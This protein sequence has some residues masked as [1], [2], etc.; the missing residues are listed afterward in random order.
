MVAAQSLEKRRQ[1]SA[2]FFQVII[3]SYIPALPNAGCLRGIVKLMRLAAFQHFENDACC[4]A[5][6]NRMTGLEHL[7]GNGV[8]SS[9]SVL[10]IPNDET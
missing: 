10:R 7:P 5:I 4:F 2:V 9:E 1:I 3:I 6:L 8:L